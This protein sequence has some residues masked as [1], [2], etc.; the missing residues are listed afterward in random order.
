MYSRSP[1]LSRIGKGDLRGKK[2]AIHGLQDGSAVMFVLP[3][4]KDLSTS[5]GY[6]HEVRFV[7]LNLTQ[8]FFS[9]YSNFPPLTKID[10]QFIPSSCGA[11][12]CSHMWVII[13]ISCNCVCDV[14]I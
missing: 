5:L 3:S 8:G 2:S 10:S 13:I 9:G 4:T 6:T 12:L 7:D 11:A 14:F 1:S